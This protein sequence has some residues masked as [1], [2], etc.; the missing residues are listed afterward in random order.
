[1]EM[2][3]LG[4]E[5]AQQMIE[6][7]PP[8]RGVFANRTLNMRAVQAVGYDMDYT[9]I[10]YRVA[11]WEMAAFDHAKEVLAALAWPVENLRFDPDRFTIGLTF[12]LRLGNV[13]KATRFG[14]VVRGQ[15]GNDLLSFAEQRDLWRNHD[16]PRH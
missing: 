5:R 8:A 2:T 1:M 16:C 7:A 3:N 9:L 15:H 12:D 10:H 13:L 11:E 6:P 14:Y 4:D